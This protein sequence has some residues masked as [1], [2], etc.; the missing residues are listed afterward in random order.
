MSQTR[1]TEDPQWAT[2]KAFNPAG[3]PSGD[4]IA[5]TSGK[6]TDGWPAPPNSPLPYQTINYLW[7]ILGDFVAHFRDFASSF[8][9]TEGAVAGLAAGEV[10]FVDSFDP[11]F[12]PGDI[13]QA[14]KAVLIPALSPV[15]E[16][17]AVDVDGQYVWIFT[18]QASSWQVQRRNREN[19][20]TVAAIGAGSFNV[21]NT[22]PTLVEM[23]LV[24]NGTHVAIAL[25]DTVRLHLVSDGSEVWEY[26]HG[27]VVHD[28]AIDHE[29]VYLV[30]AAG[31]GAIEARKILFSAGSGTLLVGDSDWDFAHGA[32]LLAC[33]T[34][35]VR[36]YVG[37]LASGGHSMSAI[38]AALGTVSA[39]DPVSWD[40][41]SS[42]SVEVR[43]IKSDGTILFNIENVA[44]TRNIKVHGAADGF[45]SD[46][47][48]IGG[49]AP[50]GHAGLDQTYYYVVIE[51]IMS[52]YSR[53]DLHQA[54]FRDRRGI[55]SAELYG[56]A[57][58]GDKIFV[59][60]EESDP[61]SSDDN[62]ERLT[63]ATRGARFTRI[64]PTTARALPMRQLVIPEGP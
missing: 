52:A 32:T 44:G 35:G 33:D 49:V 6:R 57:S 51:G 40:S 60:G 12:A 64:D 3:S 39:A 36:V 54:F 25:E 46:S 31:T 18:G 63:R 17:V 20:N 24:T 16:I 15:S 21:T 56:V 38:N 22:G 30:G 10:G 42:D 58:D 11:T 27:G 14:L 41:T 4:V 55:L 53:N 34:D 28:I 43:S 48:P 19:L 37:G 7:K 62:L 26:P 45:P 13:E 8:P 2:G 59:V 61:G 5:P 1:P 50:I 23:A 9:G 29:A 47:R